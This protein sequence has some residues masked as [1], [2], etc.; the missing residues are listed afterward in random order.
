MGKLLDLYLV[1]LPQAASGRFSG[2]HFRVPTSQRCRQSP[3]AKVRSI[4]VF[5]RLI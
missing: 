5:W 3:V 1:S 4:A 2:D